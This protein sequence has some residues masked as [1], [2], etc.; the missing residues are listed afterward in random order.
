[1]Y[2][3][4]PRS[5]AWGR[6]IIRTKWLDVNKGDKERPNYRARLVGC[7]LK[8]KDRRLDLFAATP[9]LESLRFLCSLCASRQERRQP[10]RML[11]VD[12]RR[13]YFYA[14]AKG[15]IYMEIP[16]E[17]WEDGDENRVAQLDL[18]LYGARDAAQNWTEEYTKTLRD[19]GFTVGV[20]SPCNFVHPDKEL[21]VSVHGDDF[22]VVGPA[23]ELECM[24]SGLAKA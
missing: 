4:V 19:I 7:E 1:M 16:M 17:D 15:S 20:A 21:Y 8:L 6:K 23:S 13:A 5:E 24:K 14:A 12:V 11:R 10:F 3:K 22:T 18:S 2:H 9:A